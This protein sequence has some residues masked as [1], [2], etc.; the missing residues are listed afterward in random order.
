MARR[1]RREG[2]LPKFGDRVGIQGPGYVIPAIVSELYDGVSP[3]IRI[4]KIW[5]DDDTTPAV[6]PVEDLLPWPEKTFEEQLDDWYAAERR[7]QRS[8]RR[9]ARR[10][11]QA[12]R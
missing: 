4:T 7:R 1:S 9:R 10:A 8:A 3:L 2:P 11:A 12:L 5:T 6:V